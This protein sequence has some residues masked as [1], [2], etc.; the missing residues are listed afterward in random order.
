M[1]GPVAPPAN[2]PPTITAPPTTGGPP[3]PV[4]PAY[5][6]QPPSSGP[7]SVPAAGSGGAGPGAIAPPMAPTLPEMNRRPAEKVPSVGAGCR[8]MHPEDDLSLVSVCN[9]A[10]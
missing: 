7:N 10:L 8:L 1:G 5:Q 2:Q 4:F 6:Q 3:K 9:S